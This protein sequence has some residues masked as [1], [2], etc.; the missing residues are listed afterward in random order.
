M[1]NVPSPV[2]DPTASTENKILNGTSLAVTGMLQRSLDDI[3]V[4]LQDASPPKDSQEKTIIRDT[5]D[6]MSMTWLNDETKDLPDW[7]VVLWEESLPNWWEI[8]REEFLPDRG[9][10]YVG[11]G[12][13]ETTTTQELLSLI[14]NSEI[15][16]INWPDRCSLK[17]RLYNSEHPHGG[18][19]FSEPS[20]LLSVTGV[21][22]RKLRVK[23]WQNAHG[24]VGWSK[25]EST[26]SNIATQSLDI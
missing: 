15:R 19:R 12:H 7:Q 16:A 18:C 20:M 23:D 13:V 24:K 9:E 22:P 17:W 25:P 3:F 11:I 5:C 10:S 26:I 2:A 1:S 21:Q 6:S 4:T 14:K 8:L